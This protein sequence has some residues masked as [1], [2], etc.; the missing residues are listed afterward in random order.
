MRLVGPAL[1]II[2]LLT[3]PLLARPEKVS[4]LGCV[5]FL[6]QQ[7]AQ[8]HLRLYPW[9][10]DKLDLDADGVACNSGETRPCPCD[11]APVIRV[12]NPSQT[13]GPSG[14][15]PI[16]TVG[17]SQITPIATATPIGATPI[18]GTGQFVGTPSGTTRTCP[19]AGE[20]LGLYWSGGETAVVTATRTCPTA[21]RV[22]SRRGQQWRGYA[23]DASGASDQFSVE[24]GEFVFVHGR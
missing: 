24:I 10:P 21:D 7:A 18:P 3:V 17:G 14:A 20:W 8:S 5:D 6:T 19:G 1:A 9:D 11:I 2:V 15:T 4:A 23:T 22:W 13:P 16:P 12:A